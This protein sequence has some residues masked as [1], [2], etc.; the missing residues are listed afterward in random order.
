AE[1]PALLARV[2]TRSTNYA[3]LAAMLPEYPS[4]RFPVQA[5]S[6]DAADMPAGRSGGEA[7]L[8]EWSHSAHAAQGVNCSACHAASGSG[9]EEPESGEVAP[10][11][12]ITRP[13][14]AACSSCHT[15][16]DRQLQ[17]G[18]HGM[19][20]AVGLPALQ[21][22]DARLPMQLDAARHSLGCTSYHSA[23]RIDRIAAAR[24]ACLGCHADNHSRA[25]DASPHGEGWAEVL[26]GEAPADQAV[27]CATCHM[28]VVSERIC[29]YDLVADHVQHNG[30]APRRPA[31]TMSRPDRPP[32]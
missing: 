7:A 18:H 21:P 6:R 8:E 4:D 20:R 2:S 12:W 32:A 5:L 14:D 13:G 10:E 22:G 30:Y 26:R 24:T 31:E 11:A 1:A 15:I 17:L 23:H 9:A 29:E 25:F 16:Q 19:R 27:S 28:P 3:E